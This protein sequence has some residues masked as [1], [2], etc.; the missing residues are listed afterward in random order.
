MYQEL[1]CEQQREFNQWRDRNFSMLPREM[2]EKAFRGEER[3]GSIER[4]DPTLICCECG[5]LHCEGDLQ[6]DDPC[7][8]SACAARGGVLEGRGPERWPND[9]GPLWWAYDSVVESVLVKHPEIAARHSFLVYQDEDDNIY[10]GINSGNS[11][12]EECWYPFYLDFMAEINRRIEE[13]D[14]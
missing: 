6:Y 8:D 14:Y 11:M 12:I 13:N 9:F 4:L 10:I 5:S 7:P 1:T 2:V 3:Y